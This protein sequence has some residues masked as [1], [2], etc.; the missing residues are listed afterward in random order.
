MYW[1]EAII[2]K[3]WSFRRLPVDDLSVLY[4]DAEIVAAGVKIT[5]QVVCEGIFLI[6]MLLVA[7]LR[8]V[9]GIVYNNRRRYT[10]LRRLA[11]RKQKE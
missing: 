5:Q 10:Y 3:K 1:E 2:I 6:S 9:C 8:Y 7:L 4:E 11:I